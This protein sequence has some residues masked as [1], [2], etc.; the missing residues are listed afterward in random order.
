MFA[1]LGYDAMGMMAQAIGEAGTTDSAE[2]VDAMTNIQYQGVTGSITF[3]ENRNPT[4]T[5][6]MISI[7]GGEYKFAGTYDAK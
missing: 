3:D 1:A 2:I 5:V 7:E 6:F 4:K